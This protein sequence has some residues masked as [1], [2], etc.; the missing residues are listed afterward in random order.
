MVREGPRY[1]GRGASAE[2]V[3]GMAGGTEGGREKA[4]EEEGGR[5]KAME[6]GGRERQVCI[7]G[8]ELERS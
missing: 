5:E 3:L 7:C 1:H 6:E 2:T 8:R 4:K